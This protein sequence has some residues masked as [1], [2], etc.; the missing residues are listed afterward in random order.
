[1]EDAG[2]QEV[3]GVVDRL[4]FV[5]GA[6]DAFAGVACGAEV[7]FPSGEVAVVGGGV[8]GEDDGGEV[9]PHG[10]VLTE[11]LKVVG[12]G[13]GVGGVVGEDEPV[14]LPVRLN[15]PDGHEVCGAEV[16]CG[17]DG[18][19]GRGLE[20]GREVAAFCE[21]GELG[22]VDGAVC[23]GGDGFIGRGGKLLPHF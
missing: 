6:G 12:E 22:V 16:P 4:P 2:A 10:I 3:S 17:V 13:F 8:V 14:A 20:V 9:A 11:Y 21:G 23:D 1:M 18:A 19:V 5:S 15:P 7:V